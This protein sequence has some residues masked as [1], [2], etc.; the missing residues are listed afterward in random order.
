MHYFY[1]LLLGHKRYCEYTEYIDL[2]HN[3]NSWGVFSWLAAVVV[4]VCLI[5]IGLG[6]ESYTRFSERSLSVN[7]WLSIG[8]KEY[9]YSDIESATL[10]KSFKSPNDN[11]VR[12]QHFVLNFRNGESYNFD[13]TSSQPDIEEQKEVM[14]LIKQRVTFDIVVEDPYPKG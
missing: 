10:V 5:F 12:R 7:E 3:M 8:E 9:F 1:L 4:P 6:L 11:I 14:E 2:K 13:K